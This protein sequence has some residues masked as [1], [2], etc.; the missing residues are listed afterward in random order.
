MDFNDLKL[1]LKRVYYAIDK[2]DEFNIE[3]H[4][5][6]TRKNVPLGENRGFLE[7]NIDFGNYDEAEILNRVFLIINGIAALKDHIKNKF[8]EIRKDPE[9]VENLINNSQELQLVLDLF[10]QDKH[11]YPL[12]LVR[13]SHKD[14]KIKNLKQSLIIRGNPGVTFYPNTGKI[15]YGENVSI[16]IVGE[17]V[18]GEDNFIISLE[19][20]IE[21]SMG[22][23]EKLLKHN[24]I[25]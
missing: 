10:N 15:E 4:V 7:F 5:K 11:G 3:D 18:D 25:I 13:R 19:K 17:V 8:R 24:N 9:E 16:S 12:T 6:F 2:K 23:I 1:R 22:K 21:E 14:P 20:M